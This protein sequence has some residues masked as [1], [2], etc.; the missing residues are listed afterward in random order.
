[1]V[2]SPTPPRLRHSSTE[3]AECGWRWAEIVQPDGTLEELQVPLTEAEYLHPE[4]GF[5]LPTTT[6][7]D[8]IAGQAKDILTRRYAHRPDVGVFRDLL[9]E[10][11]IAMGDHCPDTF[12]AF[13]IRD[14][15]ANRAKFIVPNEGVRPVFILEVVSPRYRKADREIK[16]RQYAQAQVQEYFILD[17]R[18][19]RKQL[20]DEALGYRLVDGFYQPITPDDDDRILS[21]TLGVWISLQDGCLVMED[22]E[23]QQRLKTSIELAA[24]NQV[25]EAEKIALEA[26]KIALE[27]EKMAAQQQAVAMAALLERYRSQFGTLPNSPTPEP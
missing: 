12:V 2:P 10:W 6:F 19:I 17:Q 7:H 23:T 3:L 9:V 16:V 14:K 11:D 1:M 22:A 5:H 25:L 26:E 15:A 18:R 27:A 20:V 21:T 4:E 24:E 8:D 13:G